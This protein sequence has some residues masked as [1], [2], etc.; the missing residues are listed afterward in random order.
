MKQLTNYQ[1]VVAAA[2][3]PER[4]VSKTSRHLHVPNGMDGDEHR[5][6]RAIVE[7]YM[8]PQ[9][10]ADAVP[11]LREVAHEIV[12]GL[13]RGISLNAVTELGERFAVRA[14]VR[15]LGWNEAI[16][17]ELLD[18]MHENYAAALERNPER[19]TEVAAAFDALV[20]TQIAFAA[21]DSVTGQL[22]REHVYG[23]QLTPEEVVSILRNWTAGD[24]G[25]LARCI[26]VIV[27]KL[28]EGGRMQAR[29]RKLAQADAAAN[30]LDA[31][32]N[33]WLRLE[34]PFVS[35][36]RRAVCPVTMPSG[37]HV[38]ADEIIML[39]WTAANLDPAVF[40]PGFAP[41]VNAQSNLVFG[42]GPH[43]CPGR[44]LTFAELR[45]VIGELMRQTEYISPAPGE[46]VEAYA[47]PIA[48]WS[49]VPVVLR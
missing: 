41:A 28:A 17:D 43:V 3:D 1:D 5:E 38:E 6:Y 7:R 12:S 45:A 11:V 25:S 21:S 9:A 22:T 49:N 24:L 27:R 23:R 8:S 30:E 37:E 46:E 32:F 35:N 33:E 16:E 4:F 34:D 40:Q 13:G 42:I 18:W 2:T 19:N 26:G 10:V 36:R 31:I 15:W 29:V 20:R 39:D 48:G 47:P 44:E 14:Q